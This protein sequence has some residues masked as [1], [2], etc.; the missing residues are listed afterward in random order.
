MTDQ[1]K[2]EKEFRNFYQ[3]YLEGHSKLSDLY[4]DSEE[5]QP[6][7]KLDRSILAAA[8][9]HKP[10]QSQL[11]EFPEQK[12]THMYSIAASFAI[13]SL[14]GLLVFNT[15]EAEKKQLEEDFSELSSPIIEAS[16]PTL[17]E[18]ASFEAEPNAPLVPA[19]P[20]KLGVNPKIPAPQASLFEQEI[21]KQRSDKKE[22]SVKPPPGIEKQSFKKRQIAP[23]AAKPAPMPMQANN[24]MHKAKLQRAVRSQ[25]T[26]LNSVVEKK[27]STPILS[28]QT[29]LEKIKQLWESA[30][31]E[32]ARKEL[33]LFRK[34]YPDYPI[35]ESFLKKTAKGQ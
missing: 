17:L 20:A 11:V 24:P 25:D 3:N 33:V 16:K 34:A 14:V 28:A 8:K 9:K 27:L 35:S 7:K 2:D 18:D 12:H 4:Q 1:I 29:W 32:K 5:I 15:W 13:F 21:G 19:S 6:S 26:K 30:Q 10:G 31:K 22:E 23:A